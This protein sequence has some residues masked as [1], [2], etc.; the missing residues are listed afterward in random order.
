MR[1]LFFHPHF[2]HDGDAHDARALLLAQRLIARGHHVTLVCGSTHGTFENGMRHR[3]LE[4]VALLE[5]DRRNGWKY[6]LASLRLVLREAY[7]LML[8]AAPPLSTVGPLLLA[9]WLRRKQVVLELREVWPELPRATRAITNP[10]TFWAM[11]QLAWLAYRS[12]HRLV[13]RTPG[14]ARLLVRRG[15]RHERIAVIPLGCSAAMRDRN[16]RSA[17]PPAIAPEVLLAVYAGP[18]DAA[19]DL[20]ALLDA[21]AVL[22]LRGRDDIR[23]LL[24]GD[25]RHKPNLIDRVRYEGLSHVLFQVPMAQAALAPLLRA[26]DVG[27]LPTADQRAIYN[28][29]ACPLLFDY[30]AAGLP[31][32]TNHAGWV[33][34]LLTTQQCGLVAT[35]QN[36]AALAD[37]LMQ[38]AD[39]RAAC[40]A[41]A[42]RAR[43]I[44]TD[45]YDDARL[46]DQF[47]QW[48][49]DQL[50]NM[51]S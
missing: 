36:P 19:H 21:A 13:A 50:N 10:F 30:L 25:G 5:L 27:L 6:Q 44:A 42:T 29:T 34:H 46:D 4:G 15:V 33:A 2:L 41:M 22:K 3:T 7:D 51:V 45:A 49:E 17:R 9:R 26:A 37:R 12:A 18:H 1:I 35:P 43:S 28:G 8:V 38:A 39:D 20:D 47:A 32:I 24:V 14:M 31:V 23:I 48:L 40:K 11:R 16:L